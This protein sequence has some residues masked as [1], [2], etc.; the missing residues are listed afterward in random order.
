M[1]RSKEATLRPSNTFDRTAGWHSLADPE[2][3]VEELSDVIEDL[4][5]DAKVKHTRRNS[6]GVRA[7]TTDP[8]T[9]GMRRWARDVA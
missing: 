8:A 7:R 2:A 6:R 9:P 5:R 3:T 4:F 1:V